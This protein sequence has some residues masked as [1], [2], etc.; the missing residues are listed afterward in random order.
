M[1]R[2]K[3]ESTINVSQ[4]IIMPRGLMSL[5]RFFISR[6]NETLLTWKK[7]AVPLTLYQAVHSRLN[8]FLTKFTSFM[9]CFLEVVALAR[10]PYMYL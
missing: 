4:K 9:D 10:V 8:L 2:E 7:G 5:Y 1:R 6:G 3:S